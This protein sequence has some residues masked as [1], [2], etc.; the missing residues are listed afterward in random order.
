M[1]KLTDY[2]PDFE[3]VGLKKAEGRGCVLICE[4]YGYE[5]KSC[6]IQEALNK[7]YQFE[8]NR[9]IPSYGTLR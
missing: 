9:E 8:Y 7:L 4:E 1:D 6:P 3:V 2:Y 5:C